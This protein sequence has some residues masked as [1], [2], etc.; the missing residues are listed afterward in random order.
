[1]PKLFKKF[2]LLIL[3]FSWI[4]SGWPPIWRNPRILSARAAITHQRTPSEAS[5]VSPIST[6]IS[7]VYPDDL[8]YDG[9][10]G[11]VGLTR[12]YLL[13][14]KWWGIAAYTE[15]ENFVSEC[16]PTTAPLPTAVLNLGTGDYKTA[17]SLAETKEGCEAFSTAEYPIFAVL[18]AAN[19]NVK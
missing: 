18:E 10:I 16:V 15:T 2:F 1:M 17:I 8:I 4:F 6:N 13:N 9:S 7:V 14:M 12:E 3:I 11:S 5:I 19:F